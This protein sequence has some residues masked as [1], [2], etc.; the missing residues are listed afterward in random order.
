MNT[1]ALLLGML[2]LQTAPGLA[3]AQNLIRNG[4][5]EQHGTIECM[6]CYHT[7]GK[8]PAVVHHWDNGNWGGFLCDREYK[9]STQDKMYDTCP[10]DRIAPQEGKVM[11][12]MMYTSTPRST[13]G[14]AAHLTAQTTE[15][16]QVGHLYDVSLWLYIEQNQKS[17]DPDWPKRIGIALL[18]QKARF[19]NLSGT[20]NLPYLPIDTIVYNQWY[21][22]RWRVRPL[23]TSK[24]LMI[25]VF[26]DKRW[27]T[28]QDYA[29]VQYFLD[30]VSV[31]EIPSDSVAVDSTEYYC[32]R[33]EPKNQPGLVPYMDIVRLLFV[34]EKSD[35]T[36]AHR[37]ALDSVAAFAKRYP[38]LVFE[39]SGHTDS[40]GSDHPI[41][42]G[43]R[44]QSALHYL[45]EICRLPMFRFISVGKGSSTPV[46]SNADEEGRRQ[47]RRVE[48]RQVQI[49]LDGMFYRHALQA[50]AENR[51]ADAFAF[52][53]KWLLKSGPE[54]S[55]IL[56]FDPRF[57]ALFGD[58]RWAAIEQKIRTGYRKF[59]Y[60]EYT[61]R[62]DS[63]RYDDRRVIGELAWEFCEMSPD[64]P[65]FILPR[66]PQAVVEQKLREHFVAFR[67][68]LE[69]IGWPKRSEF[70]TSTAGAAFI[71]LQHSL[72]S[73]AYIRWL[74]V[75]EKA[76]EE[77]EASW[78]CYAMLYDRC[79]LIAGKPQRYG[80]HVV[81]L[82]NGRFRVEPWE[83]DEQTINR[84]RAKIGLPSLPEP[85]ARAMRGEE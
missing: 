77:G 72:D 70:R 5:F 22:V 3:T 55:M 59:K 32:S 11:V 47:N 53:N 45:T 46:A 24:F 12:N 37:A 52:L 43:K 40:I 49:G 16:M 66:M 28:G 18:P 29:T 76:C 20:R 61:F 30:N 10:F 50:V 23:C 2:F 64:S 78:E 69:K 75:L 62:I 9:Q 31:A 19:N 83:G 79:Q 73:A 38:D 26:G 85:T 42:S 56:L 15:P 44:A 14:W 34:T 4:S 33:Y 63:L 35:L 81:A 51:H 25:G 13:P 6:S 57:E 54:N 60:P 74:P 1:P 8:Y 17:A 82:G 21:P 58:K 7:N 80:T 71:L 65:A 39:I 36:P 68:I 67:P 27:A 41:L 84:H 48:I